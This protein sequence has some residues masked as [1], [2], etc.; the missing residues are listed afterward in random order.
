[1]CM[2]QQIAREM[3][4]RFAVRGSVLHWFRVRDGKVPSDAAVKV[5]RTRRLGGSN[6]VGECLTERF[7]VSWAKWTGF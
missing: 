4:H 7:W 5:A 1:M 3:A 6:I 2:P